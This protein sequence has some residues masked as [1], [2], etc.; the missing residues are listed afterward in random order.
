MAGHGDVVVAGIVDARIAV[1]VDGDFDGA[2]AGAQRVEV[3]G[4]IVVIVKV[5]DG[6]AIEQ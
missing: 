6:H 1:V 5:N 4:R 3:F 2:G